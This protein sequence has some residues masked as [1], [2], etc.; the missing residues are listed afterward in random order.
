[1]KIAFISSNDAAPWG[2]SEELWSRTAIR[3]A[4]QGF[5]VAANVKGWNPEARQIGELE[6]ANCKV[7]RRW[8]ARTIPGRILQKLPSRNI[9]KFLDRFQPDFAVISQCF[10]CDGM[11]WMEECSRRNIPFVIIVQAASDQ[12]SWLADE[13]AD[14]LAQGFTSAKKSFFVSRMNL[15]TL[16]KQT[17]VELPNAKVIANPFN[18]PYDVQLPW[19]DNGTTLKLACVARLEPISKGQDLLLEV[20]K[21]EKWRQRSLEI[22]FFGNGQNCK[23]IEKLANLWKIDRVNF[24][25]Y[26]D[27]VSKIWEE[28][29]ALILPSRHEGLPLALVEAML[30][31]RTF[32]V[33]DV[34][35]DA[36]FVKDNVTGFVAKAPR[37]EFLD[38]A[39]ERAWQKKDSLDEMGR[40]ASVNVR[41]IIPADPIEAF[42]NEISALC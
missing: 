36:E 11:T 8:Y 33:T 25:G 35:G 4:K 2:G 20:L 30:C 13:G 42:V 12:Q 41:K 17:G 27:D 34:A 3:M 22:S 14:R 40:A 29:H 26:V 32:I 9:Y 5:T 37:V 7:F 23:L 6:Q 39:L 31:A 18:V 24:C 21:N 10:N 38:D 16:I 1:M 19:V 15:A 28:H